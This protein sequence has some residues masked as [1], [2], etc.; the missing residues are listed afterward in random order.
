MPAAATATFDILKT[1]S[2][3]VQVIHNGLQKNSLGRKTFRSLLR[4]YYMRAPSDG[5]LVD[6][7]RQHGNCAYYAFHLLIA[8]ADLANWLADNN[9]KRASTS[10]KWYSYKKL[11]RS[12]RIPFFS[13]NARTKELQAKLNHIESLGH[14]VLV[15][16]EHHEVC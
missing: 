9:F 2:D 16:M 15:D 4:Q 12:N 1:G 7:A 13:A 8:H 11:L 5:W 14:R 10:V 6:A 3:F